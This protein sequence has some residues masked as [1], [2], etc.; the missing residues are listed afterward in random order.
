[1]A[2]ADRLDTI[3]GVFAAGL[4]PTGNRDPFALRRAALGIIRLLEEGGLKLEID[5]LLTIAREE[6]GRQLEVSDEAIADVRA[7]LLERLRNHL[8]DGG[9]STR[10]VSAVLAA[11][12]HGLPDLRQRINAVGDFMQRPEAESLVAANKRIGNILKKN[13]L[14]FSQEI[15]TNLFVLDEERVLFDAVN[16]AREAVSP[17]FKAGEYGH[18]LATLAT[19]REPVDAYFDSVMVMDEDPAVRGNRLAQLAQVKQLFDRVAD[20]SQAD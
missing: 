10:L 17:R 18:A 9:A 13:D 7:F 14:D 1:V 8:L 12:L 16:S 19:L 15:E 2:L 20:F 11:P 3:V 4:K 5:D 6:V